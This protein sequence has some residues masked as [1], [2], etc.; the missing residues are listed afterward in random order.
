MYTACWCAMGGTTARMGQMSCNA[1]SGGGG[2]GGR[3]RRGWVGG[4]LGE[5]GGW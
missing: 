1:V 2:R 3:V 5:V 4:R